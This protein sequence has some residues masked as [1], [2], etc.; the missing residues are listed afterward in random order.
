MYEALLFLHVI[1]AIVLIGTGAGIAFFMVNS[2]HSQN[3]N[4]IAHVAGIVVL[5]DYVFTMMA[6]IAQPITGVLLAREVGWSLTEGWILVS[7]AL[8]VFVGS[9]W[10]PVLVIQKRILLLARA[11]SEAG[12]Q[13]PKSAICLYRVWFLLGLPAFTAMLAIIWVM[14]NKPVFY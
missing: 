4:L 3:P 2:F 1:G 13:L 6:A 7:I 9:C 5:A 8:Y 10:L 14:L 12:E 11:A